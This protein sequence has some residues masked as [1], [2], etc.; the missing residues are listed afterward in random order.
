MSIED[1]CAGHL[2]KPYPEL[3]AEGIG[4]PSVKVEIE[5]LSP[6]R[7][8]DRID[9]DMAVE[10]VGRTSVRF[11]YEASVGG[12]PVFKARNVAVVVDMRT[13]RPMALPGWLRERLEAA[14]Q[15]PG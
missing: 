11:R 1:F 4:F 6:V 10:H 7:Y 8:G 12:R 13:F 5:F 14:V 2:G 3:Y 15:P 9:V